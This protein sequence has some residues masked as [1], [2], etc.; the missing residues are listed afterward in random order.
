[1]HSP[2]NKVPVPCLRSLVP[3]L[4][5]NDTSLSV[6]LDDETGPAGASSAYK[7]LR[8]PARFP[9]MRL[10]GKCALIGDWARVETESPGM[11]EEG[12]R[13]CICWGM[14]RSTWRRQSTHQGTGLPLGCT[15]SP[16]RHTDTPG[17]E[18]VAFP[19]KDDGYAG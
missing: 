15:V 18:V 19:V 13:G 11:P 12:P 1:M 16:L 14:Q 9:G 7:R 6:F 17:G 3:S 5:K 8:A 2:I 10:G 4:R